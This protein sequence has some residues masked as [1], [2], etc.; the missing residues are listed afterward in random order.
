MNKGFFG[1]NWIS[2]NSFKLKYEMY[3]RQGNEA[4]LFCSVLF[5]HSCKLISFVRIKNNLC[6]LYILYKNIAETLHAQNSYTTLHRT[7]CYVYLICSRERERGI[8]CS[9]RRKALNWI[10]LIFS[11]ISKCISI[12]E[13]LRRNFLRNFTLIMA[14]LTKCVVVLCCAV[15]LCWL[16]GFRYNLW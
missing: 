10:P 5:L 3:T 2:R 4:L 1:T 6:N 14:F 12:H 8:H 7:A 11:R 16:C 13:M 15:S 9:E